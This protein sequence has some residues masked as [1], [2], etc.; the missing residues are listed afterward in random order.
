VDAWQCVGPTNIG[1]RVTSLAC[2]PAQPD[3]IWAGAAGGGVWFSENAGR[4]WV[5][6][7]ER[8]DILN[9]GALAIDPTRPDVLYCG[10]GEAN[11][12]ADSY[13]GVG[14]YRSEDGGKS[15]HLLA[16]AGSGGLPRRIGTIAVDPRDPRHLLLGGVGFL[17]V[18]RDGGRDV[19][20]LFVSRDG[21]VSWRRESFVSTGNY[22][23]HAVAFHP[24]QAG[25]LFATITEQG[26]RSGIYRSVDGGAHW[27]QLTSGLPDPARM[28]RTSLAL[29]PSAPNVV[30]A[31]AADE[32]S[33]R[34]DLPLG[35]FRSDDAGQTW[36]E[37]GGAHFR[38]EAQMS[39]GN[40]IVVDPGNANLVLC[41]GVDLHRSTDGGKTWMRATRW[42]ADR[43]TPHYAHA[44]HHCLLMPALAPGR[45]YDANDGGLDLSVNGGAT[46]ENRSNGLA[47]TMYYDMD[48]AQSDGRSFGGGAQDNGTLAT[49]TGGSGDHYEI[50]GGDGGWIAYDP[51]N[52]G[53]VFASYYNI[54]IYRFQGGVNKDVSPPCTDAERNDVW[55]AYIT[56]DPVDPRTMYVGSNRVWQSRDGGNTWRALSAPLDGS[57]ISCIEVARADPRRLYVGTENGSI[58][59]STDRGRRWSPN[60]SS[61]SLPGHMITRLNTSPKDAE[62]VYATVANFGH[63]H[64]FRSDDGG[65]S[66][67]DVDKGQLPDVPLHSLA[68]PPGIVPDTLY[69][70]GDAGVFT[71][72]DAGETWQDLTRNLPHVGVVDLVYHVRDRTLSAATYGRSIWRLANQGAAVTPAAESS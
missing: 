62:R 48:V 41:G 38:N 56:L 35:V 64:V 33:E 2:H 58:F 66:W 68:I 30:Y 6:L 26:A 23:C 40:S 60:I 17:E 12:S 24:T 20:G 49:H 43:G 53:R 59:R 1:G 45:V 52:A 72:A 69:V 54:N 51:T 27:S 15:W 57:T 67:I 70:C 71:S 44:D 34:A 39:Y 14:L 4:S 29:C 13:A 8:Q 16:P 63:S 32:Q 50:L 9:V 46:W 55:M 7:W 65:R 42:N 21:G 25:L 37:I 31:L 11:L 36:R 18:G 28:G 3:R 22:W 47:I 19:G 5:S 61:S 10:T